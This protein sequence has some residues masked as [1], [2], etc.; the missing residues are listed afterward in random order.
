MPR[1]RRSAP[2]TARRSPRPRCPIS[3]T[4]SAP[5]AGRACSC[6]PV[7][8]VP[9]GSG[10]RGCTG[11]RWS[12]SRARPSPATWSRSPIP[13][14]A[15]SGAGSS[16]RARRFG[17][18]CS[19]EGRAG[20]RGVPRAG[21]SPPA[22]CGAARFALGGDEG[23]SP[24]Q[25][26]RGRAARARRRRLRRR[27]RRTGDDARN[28]Q[29]EAIFDALEERFRPRRSSRPPPRATPSSKGSPLGAPRTRRG[30]AQVPC[31]ENGIVL[32]VEPLVGQ[33]TGMF[34]DQRANRIA[35]ASWPVARAC[36]TATRTPAASRCRPRGRGAR[37]ATASTAR[38]ARWRGSG[39]RGR[40]APQGAGRGGRHLPLPRDG[41]APHVRPGRHRSAEVRAG[42]QGSRGCPQG[43]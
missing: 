38:R 33:K 26:R 4:G 12:A 22:I 1:C 9:C 8:R 42:A 11:T 16:I 6:A 36:S 2:H 20:R 7:A 40:Q 5:T 29:R 10:T 3:R 17:S 34:L 15:S 19:R 43:I 28:G 37:E 21:W 39:A 32:E 35:S 24:G 18:G 23:V 31:R 27:L 13:R 41:Q 14:G 25:Q 30:Q